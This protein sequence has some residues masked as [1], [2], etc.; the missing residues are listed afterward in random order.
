MYDTQTLNNTRQVQHASMYAALQMCARL[1]ETFQPCA[2][3]GT[4]CDYQVVIL[5]FVFVIVA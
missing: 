3:C 1:C 4:V 2:V 5:S